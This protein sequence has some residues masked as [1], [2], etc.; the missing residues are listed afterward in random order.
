VWQIQ[1]GRVP[2]DDRRVLAKGDHVAADEARHLD[3]LVDRMTDAE[4]VPLVQPVLHLVRREREG[5]RVEADFGAGGRLH[6]ER[7]HHQRIGA[8]REVA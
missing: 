7:A 5:D 8:R 1:G 4:E 6:V 3:R 2:G